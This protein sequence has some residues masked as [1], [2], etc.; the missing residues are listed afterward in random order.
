MIFGQGQDISVADTRGDAGRGGSIPPPGSKPF[1][2]DRM[3]GPELNCPSCGAVKRHGWRGGRTGRRVLGFYLD[4]CWSFCNL[5]G[6]VWH[7]G[8]KPCSWRH[9]M[10]HEDIER[11]IAS[12]LA[13]GRRWGGRK[14][15][16][17]QER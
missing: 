6:C 17:R 9:E 5:C 12:R 13:A 16:M 2:H 10:S 4:G 3:S 14:G 1:V 8:P 7:A 15:T 11:E